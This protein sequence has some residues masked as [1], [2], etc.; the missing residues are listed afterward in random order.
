[1]VSPLARPEAGEEA[2]ASGFREVD[3]HPSQPYPRGG[4]DFEPASRR[5]EAHVHRFY[6]ELGKLTRDITF[7]E[8]VRRLILAGP[9][10]RTAEFRRYSQ[11][12][13]RTASSP[14]ST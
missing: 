8:G 13:S 7:R 5:T 1:M 6:N 3:V 9:R 11:T 2:R 12:S 14:R 4:T 10:E